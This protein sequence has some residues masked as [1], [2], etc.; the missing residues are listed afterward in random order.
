[1]QSEIRVLDEP[2]NHSLTECLRAL[3]FGRPVMVQR[4]LDGVIEQ[5][6]EMERDDYTPLLDH[7]G[8]EF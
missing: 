4:F 3:R 8:G 1:M 2:L 5:C 7:T 6:E